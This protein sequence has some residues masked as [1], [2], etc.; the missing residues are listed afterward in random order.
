VAAGR[1]SIDGERALA[2]RVSGL[3]MLVGAA[4][5]AVSVALPPRAAE[6]DAI[7]LVLVALAAVLGSVLLAARRSL[8]EWVLG[9]AIATGTILV[10]V[11]THQGGTV[12]TGTDDNEMLYVWICLLAFNFLSLPHALGQLALV[13]AAYSVLLGDVSAGEAITRWMISVTTLLVA[14][15]AVYRLRSSRER[16]VAELSEQARRDGLTGLLNRAALEERAIQELAR[17]RRHGDPLSLIVLDLDGFKLINDTHGHPSGDEVLRTVAEHLRRQTRDVDAVARLGG[18]EF[19][20]LLPATTATE[21]HV[22]AQ[23]LIR[24]SHGEEGW[25]ALSLGVATA[26]PYEHSFETLWHE[27]D[28]AMYEA[29]RAGGDTVRASARPAELVG[30]G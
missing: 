12:H 18:D 27:A 13:A 17:A 6:S 19:A 2:T 24:A 9:M 26:E 1:P 4:L 7:V 10:T 11:A 29:K 23:R 22:V 16:L 3:M 15:L 25:P 5:G 21:A 30:A 28:T 20:I 8:P 14:G